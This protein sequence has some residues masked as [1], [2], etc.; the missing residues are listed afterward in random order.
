MASASEE[1]SGRDTQPGMAVPWDPYRQHRPMRSAGRTSLTTAFSHY[2]AL[3]EG[4]SP[5]EIACSFDD[6]GNEND[7][8]IIER[9]I[10]FLAG[11]FLDG[12]IQTYARLG[13]GGD[14]VRLP[15]SVWEIDDP[16]RRFATGSIN[17][18]RP[19]DL[20]AVPTH[21]IFIDNAQWDA[22]MEGYR[23][24]LLPRSGTSEDPGMDHDQGPS[25]I[26]V[27]RS[28]DFGAADAGSENGA[29]PNSL[30]WRNEILTLEGVERATGLKKSTIYAKVTAGTFP[31][32]IPIHG[33]R[34]GWRRGEV[35]DWLDALGSAQ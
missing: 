2:M 30:L 27:I 22:A 24:S 19:H 15:A 17:L 33:T 3:S 10:Q 20:S 29:Q 25:D 34:R 9:E 35:Q 14:P 16:I 12:R 13:G 23:Q 26:A 32:Q 11:V 28:S 8:D 18:E 6:G 5:A 1:N 21:W 4:I 7:R 31:K